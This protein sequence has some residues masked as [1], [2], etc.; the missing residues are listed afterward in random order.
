VRG[1]NDYSFDKDNKLILKL[2]FS[3]LPS[4]SEISYLE[5]LAQ[6]FG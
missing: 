6:K 3:L 5:E 1:F 4:K 2:S